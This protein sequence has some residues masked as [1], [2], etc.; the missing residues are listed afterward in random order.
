VTFEAKM[1]EPA[2]RQLLPTELMQTLRGIWEHDDRMVVVEV[3]QE[4]QV[5]IAST[6]E[7]EP[8]DPRPVIQKGIQVKAF[9]AHRNGGSHA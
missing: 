5:L 1:M 3:D 9:E 6:Y 2:F 8:L 7:G 4:R